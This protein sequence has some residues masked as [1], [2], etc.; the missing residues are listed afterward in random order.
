MKVTFKPL[1]VFP[2]S[3][4]A[5]LSYERTALTSAGI[6]WID[7]LPAEEMNWIAELHSCRIVYDMQELFQ[8]DIVE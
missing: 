8:E 2:I 1:I 6:L 7:H 4:H 3:Q 5:V